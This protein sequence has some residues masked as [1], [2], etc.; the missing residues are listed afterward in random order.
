MTSRPRTGRP[1]TLRRVVT[2]VN[3]RG[4]HARA[5]HKF[6][7]CAERFEAEI[8]VVKQDMKVS[9]SSI[10]GLLLLAAATGSEIELRV[11]GPEAKA[12]LEAICALIA[13]RFDEDD[14]APAAGD[15]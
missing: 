6:V 10:M 5:A 9:G 13:D 15:S 3:K 4:L 14:L 12:A 1:R 11:S 8:V 7:K 2:I